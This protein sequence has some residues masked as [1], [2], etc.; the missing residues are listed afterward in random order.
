MPRS[1][2]LLYANPVNIERVV[3]TTS[4]WHESSIRPDFIHRILNACEKVQPNLLLLLNHPDHL[5]VKS[6]EGVTLDAYGSHDPDGDS[7]SYLWFN[8]P[9]AGTYH[10]LDTT[11]E[12]KNADRF[13]V[14]APEVDEEVTAHF[15]L[16][17][18]DKGTPALTACRRII[19][20]ITPWRRVVSRSAA[21][22]VPFARFRRGSNSFMYFPISSRGSSS[23]PRHGYPARAV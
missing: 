19:V 6:G 13:N 8:Y 15:I 3:A 21:P 22:G 2:L 10:Q 16:K 9:E 14:T 4:C 11:G 18:S 12:A 23:S 1:Q 7:I 5:T 17:L 20:T